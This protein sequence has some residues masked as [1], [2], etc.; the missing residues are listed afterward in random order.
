MTE[1]YSE[2]LR[3]VQTRLELEKSLELYREMQNS[4]EK[5]AKLAELALK[6][7]VETVKRNIDYRIIHYLCTQSRIWM[8]ML[9][10]HKSG[11]QKIDGRKHYSEEDS[12]NCLKDKLKE[13]IGYE[14]NILSIGTGWQESTDNIKFE[15][16]RNG[17][18]SGKFM[19][20][21]PIQENLTVENIDFAGWGK[22]KL[23]AVNDNRDSIIHISYDTSSFK[24]RFD[25]FIT[26][27]P[28]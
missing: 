3:A 21:I 18:S 9:E 8:T 28:V 2:K 16:Y 26:P 15:Y 22:V 4:A 14:V 27:K 11:A 17:F 24:D 7:A 6:D 20:S 23:L 5:Y 19:L 13:I 25:E 10:D 1:D 12:F